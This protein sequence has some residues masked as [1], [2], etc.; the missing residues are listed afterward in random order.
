[1]AL[2]RF[3][4]RSVV[5]WAARDRRSDSRMRWTS[6]SNRG[7]LRRMSAAKR[8]TRLALGCVL[9][10]I[11]YVAT[12]HLGLFFGAVAGFATLVWPPTGI[13][14]AA[15]KLFG[16]SLWPAVFAGALIVNAIHGA[17]L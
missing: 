17:P 1:P 13:A 9:L 5:R 11:V 8:S 12:A 14:L 7:T 3:S 2:E 10:F 4:A 16:F 15:L 6:R